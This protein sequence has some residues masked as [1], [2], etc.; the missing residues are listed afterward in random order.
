[1]ATTAVISSGTLT[2]NRPV[3]V[4]ASALLLSGML[5]IYTDVS[6]QKSALYVIGAALG[7]VLYH[8]S[9]GFTASWRM[10]ILFAMR[11]SRQPMLAGVCKPG[12]SGSRKF[13]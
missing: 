1:M 2:P 4:L 6:G 7:F 10:A 11:V 8:A 12:V 13:L 9:F 3:I 5:F